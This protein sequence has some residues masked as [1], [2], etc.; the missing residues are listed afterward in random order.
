MHTEDQRFAPN[1]SFTMAAE[2]QQA[3]LKVRI[4]PFSIVSYS[5][6]RLT[7]MNL[8]R[9]VVELPCATFAVLPSRVTF[10][11]RDY[12]AG[13]AKIFQMLKSNYTID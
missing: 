10:P 3:L 1:Q 7:L 13:R 8:A 2:L 12:K 9:Q 11:S 4:S 6:I 5:L